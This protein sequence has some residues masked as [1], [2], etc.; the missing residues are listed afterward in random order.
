MENRGESLL[1]VFFV[2][3]KSG[4]LRMILDTRDCNCFFKKPAATHLPSG[5]AFGR[6]EA[7]PDK[8]VYFAAGD[9]G[10]LLSPGGPARA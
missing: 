7:S 10:L 3:K 1:G 8:L 5:C 4:R 9:I 6:L 2:K